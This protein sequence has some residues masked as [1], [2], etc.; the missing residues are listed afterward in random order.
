[1]PNSSVAPGLKRHTSGKLGHTF[2]VS[3]SIG[4]RFRRNFT[5]IQKPPMMQPPSRYELSQIN[6]GLRSSAKWSRLNSLPLNF[7]QQDVHTDHHSHGQPQLP[8]LYEAQSAQAPWMGA[9]PIVQTIG[10]GALG[11]YHDIAFQ[12][13]DNSRWQHTSH[14]HLACVT[15]PPASHSSTG[16]NN[17]TSSLT[18]L[19]P[20]D[21]GHSSNAWMPI[22]IYD[23]VHAC[24]S[25]TFQHGRVLIFLKQGSRGGKRIMTGEHR[26]WALPARK[27]FNTLGVLWARPFLLILA[28][29]CARS[30]WSGH[31]NCSGSVGRDEILLGSLLYD[32]GVR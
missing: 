1:M 6:P 5:R 29:Y 3:C 4:T 18:M 16:S 13:V 22:V 20:T 27:S 32:D 9:A 31:N 11:N 21:V 19:A 2:C 7:L 15:A 26:F 14:A 28:E 10:I 23:Q 25:G 24:I 12:N 30:C 17:P 8:A